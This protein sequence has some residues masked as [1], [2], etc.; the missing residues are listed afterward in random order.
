MFQWWF[1]IEDEEGK[2]AFKKALANTHSLSFL[3]YQMKN[4]GNSYPSS[5]LALEEIS[6]RVVGLVYPVLLASGIVAGFPRTN[7]LKGTPSK[8]IIS[9]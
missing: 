6:P 3:Y 5:F 8:S 4:P 1:V 9:L 2:Y 7:L